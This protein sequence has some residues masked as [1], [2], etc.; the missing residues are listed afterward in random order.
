M[1][2]IFILTYFLVTS[3]SSSIVAQEMDSPPSFRGKDTFPDYFKFVLLSN[4]YLGYSK[5]VNFQSAIKFVI[6]EKGHVDSVELPDNLKG[7][8]ALKVVDALESTHG[9]WNPE[10]LNGEVVSKSKPL[11]LPLHF[12]LRGGCSSNSSTQ[13]DENEKIPFSFDLNSSDLFEKDAFIFEQLYLFS[14]FGTEDIGDTI[15]KQ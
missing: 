7:Y 9:Q 2:Y 6:D 12:D 3:V 14:P 11:I 1:K 10:I 13:K 8:L 4:H 15:K 5:C